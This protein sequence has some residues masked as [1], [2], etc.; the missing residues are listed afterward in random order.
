VPAGLDVHRDT[1]VACLIYGNGEK[2]FMRRTFSTLPSGLAQLRSWLRTHGCTGAA[3]ESTGPFWRPVYDALEGVVELT[4]CNAQHVKNVPG[5]KTDYND[6]HWLAKLLRC[7]LLSNSYVP[8]RPLRELREVTR[9][10][11]TLTRSETA[12]MNRTHKTM[13]I[14]GIKLSSVASEAFGVSGR[15]MIHAVIKGD[16][17]PAEIADLAK[18]KLRRKKDQLEDVFQQPVSEHRRRLLALQM[19]DMDR[20]EASRAEAELLLEEKLAPYG[21]FLDRVAAMPGCSRFSA[22][23]LLAEI[24]PDMAPWENTFKKLAAWAGVAPGNKQSANKRLRARTRDGNPYAKTTLIMI[25]LAASRDADSRFQQLYNSCKGRLGKKRALVKIAHAWL[26]CFFEMMVRN[27]PYRET[28][29]S[30][31]DQAKEQRKAKRLIKKL[32]RLGY[33]I[34]APAQA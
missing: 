17:T 14:G 18:A 19:R 30:E 6:A 27:E 4:V 13:Q 31:L 33:G 26:R 22:A 24:G 23:V 34:T 15:L 21:E 9:Y 5:R 16:K 11:Q 10:L 12:F 20:L 28:R 25:A 29:T 8:P 32:Q 3:M 2:D 7:G 1:V